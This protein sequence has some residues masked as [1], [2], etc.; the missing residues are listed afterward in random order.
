M[1]FALIT[2]LIPVF[3]GKYWMLVGM[4]SIG[5]W[6]FTSLAARFGPGGRHILVSSLWTGVQAGFLLLL[7]IWDLSILE[8]TLPQGFELRRMWLELYHAGTISSPQTETEFVPLVSGILLATV[9]SLATGGL[10]GCW[11]MTHCIN[12]VSYFL[13]G[14]FTIAGIYNAPE[15]LP[16]SL[17]AI[18]PGQVV[19]LFGLCLAHHALGERLWRRDPN[20]SGPWPMQGPLL[21]LGLAISLAGGLLMLLY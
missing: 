9:G 5:L 17:A 8:K 16:F 10:T 15:W 7:G 12:Y 11:L 21:G 14:L 13:A 18:S 3:G 19:L 20:L 2:S 1:V 4:Q 6:A